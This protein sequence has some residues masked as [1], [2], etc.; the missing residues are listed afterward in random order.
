MGNVKWA[1][2]LTVLPHR[3]V[4]SERANISQ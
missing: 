1:C 3:A 4:S 2:V